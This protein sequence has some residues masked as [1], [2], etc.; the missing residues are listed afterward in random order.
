ME[1]EKMSNSIRPT[2]YRFVPWILSKIENQQ[3]PLETVCEIIWSIFGKDRPDGKLTST[4]VPRTLRILQTQVPNIK[5][6]YNILDISS[7]DI[8]SIGNDGE[9]ILNG[10]QSDKLK[11]ITESEILQWDRACLMATRKNLEQYV[12]E[13]VLRKS[14]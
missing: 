3:A 8:I 12:R 10:T 9:K 7:D 2:F 11:D 13:M 14:Y 4:G 1:G 5:G 6:E